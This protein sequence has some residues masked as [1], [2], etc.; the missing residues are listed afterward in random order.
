MDLDLLSNPDVSGNIDPCPWNEA[1]DNLD[2]RCTVK[3]TSIYEYFRCIEPIDKVR[4]AS[5]G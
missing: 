5:P 1:E 4:Y 3:D 2:H